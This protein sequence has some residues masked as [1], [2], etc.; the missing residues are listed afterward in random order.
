MSGQD[1]IRGF[2]VQTLICLLDALRT[3]AP[4]WDAV[5]LEPDIAG[6]KVDIFWEYVG[7]TLA[8]QVKSS[9]NQISKGAVTKWCEELSASR[10]ADRYQLMLAGPIAASVLED[11][12]F[13]GVEVPVPTSMDTLALIDQAVTKLDRYLLASGYPPIPLP[14]REDMVS[15]VSAR[16][17]DGSIRANRLTKVKFDGWLRESILIGY[18]GAVDIRISA[19]CDIVW[20]NLQISAPSSLGQ[21]AFNVSLPITV[22][23]SGHSLAIVEWFLLK[24]NGQGLKLLYQPTSI[25]R[26]NVPADIGVGASEIPFSEFAVNPGTALSV[27]LNFLPVRKD[28]FDVATWAEGEYCIELW[29]K[30]TGSAQP[31]KQR[32]DS[33]S[34][35]ID[36]RS[37][38]QSRQKRNIRFKSSDDYIDSL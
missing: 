31:K 26:S 29:V 4:D 24:V 5:T 37:A 38:L 17:L 2:L 9:K 23:N 32:E 28:G 14:M 16:L 6:D 11:A 33:I 1:A 7:S 13:H 35:S 12:P 18:P 10:S 30:Y 34:I 27:Y 25:V 19:N 15:L 3:G 8:Q 36:D 21:Q 22:I 20:S